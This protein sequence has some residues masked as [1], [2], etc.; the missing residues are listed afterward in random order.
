[1]SDITIHHYHVFFKLSF[2]VQDQIAAQLDS[3]GLSVGKLGIKGDFQSKE[4]LKGLIR[5]KELDNSLLSYVPFRINTAFFRQELRRIN[6]YQVN[7][8]V[9]Q[10]SNE[11]FETRKPLIGYTQN[12]L[13]VIIHPEWS[14]Y[15]KTNHVIIRGWASWKWLQYMQRCNPST[16]AISNKL[17]PPQHR[18]PLKDQTKY[19]KKILGKVQLCCI[20]SGQPLA[21]DNLSLDHYLPWSFVTHD[22]LWNLIPT[23]R[24]VNSSKSNNLPDRKYF[25]PFVQLQYLGLRI[26]HQNMTERTWGKYIEPFISELRVTDKDDLLNLD[27]LRS[28]YEAVLLPQINLAISHGFTPNWRYH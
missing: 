1:M 12:S 8:K 17:F 7:R 10:L 14:D 5:E 26:T 28:A 23:S 4:Y 22:L 6:D 16:P 18:E 27:K 15:F 2:G 13:A 9:V 11:N 3:L 24:G 20:Y 25:D 19:W 21:L